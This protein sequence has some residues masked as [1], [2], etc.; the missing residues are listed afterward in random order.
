MEWILSTHPPEHENEVII[1]R[2]TNRGFRTPAIDVGTYNQTLKCWRP[3]G[4]NGNW[5]DEVLHW[6]ELPVPP[7]KLGGAE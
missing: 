4:G 1:H 6:M 3:R 5:N 2:T 7:S